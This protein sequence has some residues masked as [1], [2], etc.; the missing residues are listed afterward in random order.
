MAK[1]FLIAVAL[2]DLAENQRGF[3]F[4]KAGSRKNK[5]FKRGQTMI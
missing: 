2:R 5:E 3:A 1:G 4:Q